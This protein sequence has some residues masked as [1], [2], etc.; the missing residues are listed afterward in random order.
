MNEEPF[1]PIET[2]AKHFSVSVPTIRSWY[3]T[4]RIPVESYIKVGNTYRFR[5]S[6]VESALLPNK[7]DPVNLEAEQHEHDFLFAGDNDI[8]NDV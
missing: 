3:R 1:V 7:E 2:L 4:K 5:V 6:T 8:D